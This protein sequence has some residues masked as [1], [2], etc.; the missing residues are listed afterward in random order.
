MKKAKGFRIPKGFRAISEF[1]M[2]A[3]VHLITDA[4]ADLVGTADGAAVKGDVV[5][6]LCGRGFRGGYDVNL[7]AK[8]TEATFGRVLCRRCRRVAVPVAADDP[9]VANERATRAVEK[10]IDGYLDQIAA[11]GKRIVQARRRLAALRAGRG[12][13]GKTVVRKKKRVAGRRLIDF[14]EE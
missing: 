8:K 4:A 9:F 7:W 13:I 10:R 6:L 11:I 12:R 1:S 3:T 14:R 5:P 2:R